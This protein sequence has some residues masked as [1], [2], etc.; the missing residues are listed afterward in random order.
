MI[1]IGVLQL[2]QDD[3]LSEENFVELTVRVIKHFPLIGNL[4]ESLKGNKY[5]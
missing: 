3:R 5:T 1:L 2:R 4:I